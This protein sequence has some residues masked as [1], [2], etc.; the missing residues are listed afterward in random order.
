MLVANETVATEI[1]PGPIRDA[2]KELE[3]RGV[4]AQIHSPVNN[5]RSLSIHEEEYNTPKA[6]CLKDGSPIAPSSVTDLYKRFRKSTVPQVTCRISLI[7]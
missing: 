3:S 2:A 1:C 7:S 4:V 5:P 6:T